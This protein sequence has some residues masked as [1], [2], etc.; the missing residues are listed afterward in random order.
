MS[1]MYKLTK[2]ASINS[3]R[4][5]TILSMNDGTQMTPSEIMASRVIVYD[6]TSAFSLQYW[7]S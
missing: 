4:H 7:E 2:F 1:G 3:V 5:S 6:R